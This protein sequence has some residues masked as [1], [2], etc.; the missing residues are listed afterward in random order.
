MISVEKNPKVVVFSNLKGGVGKTFVSFF[1]AGLLA[2]Q[3]KR[4]LVIDSDPQGN[5]SD[6]YKMPKTGI[7]KTSRDIFEDEDSKAEDLVKKTHIENIDIIPGTVSLT[8]AELNISSIAGREQCMK[9]FL[10]RNKGYLEGYDYIFQDVNPSFSI[11]NQNC[12]LA[13]DSLI[14]VNEA[15]I[16]SMQGSEEFVKLWTHVRKRLGKEDNVKAFVVNKFKKNTNLNKEFW[17][18]IQKHETFQNILMENYI[19]NRIKY[20]EMAL[21]GKALTGGEELTP[22]VNL[23]HEL[24]MKGVL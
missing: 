5:S 17:D 21:E 22:Y 3:G 15:T 9:R 1:L 23:L 6:I 13:S 4:L 8:G 14:L 12:F 18:Y 24:Q 7:L 16:H 2:Q 10:E 11:I 20:E 19:P